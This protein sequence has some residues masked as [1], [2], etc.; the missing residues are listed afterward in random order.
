VRVGCQKTLAESTVA[1]PGPSVKSPER[2]LT[3]HLLVPA[4]EP[5]TGQ[6]GFGTCNCLFANQSHWPP[7]TDLV[8]VLQRFL[9]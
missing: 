4:P 2:D 5:V 3:A 1:V 6:E 9:I 8:T 7:P